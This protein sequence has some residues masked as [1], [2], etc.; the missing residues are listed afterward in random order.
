M[1]IVKQG[2]A[3]CTRPRFVRLEGMPAVIRDEEIEGLKDL[4]QSHHSGLGSVDDGHQ[5]TKTGFLYEDRDRTHV[6]PAKR[7]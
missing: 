5:I 3:V 2:Y 6:L 7:R 4:V 1:T